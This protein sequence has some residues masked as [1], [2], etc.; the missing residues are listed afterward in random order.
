VFQILQE[1]K[2]YLKPEKCEF[3]KEEFEF[4]GVIVRNGQIRMD[5]KTV[6][7][8]RD[9]FTVLPRSAILNV[10]KGSTEMLCWEIRVVAGVDRVIGVN[11]L[12]A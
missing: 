2:L 3:E 9:A 11:P 7:V 5:P 10:D 8:I 6:A 12:C 1:N 4:L